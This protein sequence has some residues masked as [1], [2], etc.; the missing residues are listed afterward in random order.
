M[1]MFGIFFCTQRFSIYYSFHI[2]NSHRPIDDF[3][4]FWADSSSYALQSAKD[5][6]DESRN[7]FSRHRAVWSRTQALAALF[8]MLRMTAAAGLQR[9]RT[10]PAGDSV[11]VLFAFFCQLSLQ[12]AA[13]EITTSCTAATIQSVCSSSMCLANAACNPNYPGCK[14][15]ISC[16][17]SWGPPI[18]GLYPNTALYTPSEPV[19]CFCRYSFCC[20]TPGC[21][22]QNYEACPGCSAGSY[23]TAAGNSNMSVTHMISE[24]L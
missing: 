14:P 10:L 19:C 2:N 4:H 15:Q 12:V 23:Y 11:T 7:A 22:F 24:Y 13:N 5:E 20:Y 18:V 1:T 21:T 8:L 17:G 16:C 6:T 9:T 3:R